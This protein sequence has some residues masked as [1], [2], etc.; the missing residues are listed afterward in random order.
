[1]HQPIYSSWVVEI[2]AIASTLGPDKQEL[3]MHQPIYSSWV[4]ETAAIGQHT[5]TRQA[6][7]IYAPTN[8]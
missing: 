5:R 3:Y 8:I 2:A 7:I 6:R 1:M 4:V